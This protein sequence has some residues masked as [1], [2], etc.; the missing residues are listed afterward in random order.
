MKKTFRMIGAE[1]ALI[2][3]AIPFHFMI[4][5]ASV[6]DRGSTSLAL[7]TDAPVPLQANCAGRL[8]SAE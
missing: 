8:K 7:S 1:S 3:V 5:M 6:P 4:P 2:E